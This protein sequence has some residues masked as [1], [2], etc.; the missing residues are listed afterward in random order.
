MYKIHYHRWFYPLL[1]VMCSIVLA[2]TIWAQP[3]TDVDLSLV[4]DVFTPLTA[5]FW[6]LTWGLIIEYHIHNRPE[7]RARTILYRTFEIID[8]YYMCFM[9]N[10]FFVPVDGWLMTS[11]LRASISF[12]VVM[13]VWVWLTVWELSKK[14]KEF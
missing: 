9:L 3:Q 12:M 5:I 11:I 2:W 7:T 13:L 14:K 1:F 4:R 6:L 10:L 8:I